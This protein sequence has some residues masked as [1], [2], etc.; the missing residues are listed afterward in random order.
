MM[1]TRLIFD[2]DKDG[3]ELPMRELTTLANII[4]IAC[5]QRKIDVRMVTT[6]TV[7]EV[8]EVEASLEDD[9]RGHSI[10]VR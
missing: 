10:Y 3:N 9:R 1:I 5:E 6:G 8:N 4:R 2:L 7:F